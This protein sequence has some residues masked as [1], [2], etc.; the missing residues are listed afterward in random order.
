LPL[1]ALSLTKR[2]GILNN[3]AA[4]RWALDSTMAWRVEQRRC[5]SWCP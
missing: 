2:P 1:V 4:L 5:G 3:P